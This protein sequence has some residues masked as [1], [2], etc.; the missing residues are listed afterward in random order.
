MGWLDVLIVLA[1]RWFLVLPAF[2]LVLLFS[3]RFAH[4]EPVYWAQTEVTFMLPQSDRNPN[5]Y[6]GQTESLIAAAGLVAADLSPGSAG[7]ET[8]S[9]E[10]ALVGQGVRHGYSVKLPNSGG[11]W[12]YNFD[13]AALVV[14]VVGTSENEARALLASVLNRIDHSLS[15]REVAAEVR[16]EFRIR[17]RAVPSS[18]QVALEAG[19]PSQAF[20]VS[21]LLGAG[22][23]AGLTL[24][25]DNRLGRRERRRASSAV[26]GFKA[27]TAGS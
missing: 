2:A 14:Q 16:P 19:H 23:M 17:Y 25:L 3:W 18:P 26:H 15:S 11:Q 21:V 9:T 12:A 8:S 22:C 10:V 24:A 6:A 1:R 4:P 13:R 20:V 7:A 27:Q 5:A